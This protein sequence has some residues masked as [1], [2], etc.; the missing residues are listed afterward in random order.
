MVPIPADA[1]VLKSGSDHAQ[2]FAPPVNGGF[3]PSPL[4]DLNANDSSSIGRR[5]STKEQCGQMNPSLNTQWPAASNNF[6]LQ[7]TMGL[8]QDLHFLVVQ[9]LLMGQI[10]LVN[11][12]TGLPGAIYY[13]PAAPPGSVRVPYPPFSV[14]YPLSPGVPML[15]LPTITLRANIVKQIQ[16]SYLRFRI[17]QWICVLSLDAIE[18]ALVEKLS[19]GVYMLTSFSLAISYPTLVAAPHM[20]I[21]SYALAVAVRIFPHAENAY[22][23]KAYDHGNSRIKI[24]VNYENDIILI[25]NISTQAATAH[26]SIPM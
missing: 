8:S 24:I 15:P 10:S 16:V 17:R 6:H 12:Y 3:Q 9:A 13:Y 4:T 26:E 19:A 14:P 18:D 23:I 7:Q 20:L 21:N 11:D 22:F 1:Q 2:A 5:P 25:Y